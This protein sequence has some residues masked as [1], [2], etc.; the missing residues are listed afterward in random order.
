MLIGST[1]IENILESRLGDYH[2]ERIQ[3]QMDDS[4]AGIW[5][6]KFPESSSRRTHSV[7]APDRCRPR[8]RSRTRWRRAVAAGPRTPAGYGRIT[9]PPV[10]SVD[11]T[12]GEHG[13]T[14]QD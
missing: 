8:N 3:I 1:V 4:Y 7:G 5:M 14:C 10:I 9:R 2:L 11:W 13:T 12:I 6:R